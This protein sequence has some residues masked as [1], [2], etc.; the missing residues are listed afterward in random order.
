MNVK[1]SV[2]WKLAW[3]TEVLRENL[4]WTTFSTKNPTWP[5]LASNLGSRGAKPATNCLNYDTASY[6]I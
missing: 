5:D 4:P 2:E 6:A 1:L 3:E